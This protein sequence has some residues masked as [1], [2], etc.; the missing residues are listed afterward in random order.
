MRVLII[1]EILFWYRKGMDELYPVPE[2]PDATM[3]TGREL[4]AVLE[5]LDDKDLLT[6]YTSQT[7]LRFR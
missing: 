2:K 4:E 5:R 3:Y 7:C 1:N 6:A